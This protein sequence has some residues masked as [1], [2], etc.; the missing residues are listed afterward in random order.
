MMRL[1]FK[2]FSC[3]LHFDHKCFANIN[4][5]AINRFY[6]FL[7]FV[8]SKTENDRFI[9]HRPMEFF[10]N[11]TSMRFG[12]RKIRKLSEQCRTVCIKMVRSHIRFW[13][14]SRK[15]H[16][17]IWFSM[18]AFLLWTKMPYVFHQQTIYT[19]SKKW[20]ITSKCRNAMNF[21]GKKES[22]SNCE[23]VMVV[24]QPKNPHMCTKRAWKS[25]PQ[26]KWLVNGRNFLGNGAQIGVL[27]D[28]CR[29][30]RHFS[31]HPTT[32][33]WAIPFRYVKKTVFAIF[34]EGIA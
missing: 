29:Q 15:Y 22:E 14:S 1:I 2:D 16:S 8:H 34:L 12:A 31:F 26:L 17:N 20:K 10:A 6:F 9:F 7:M 30:C 18:N 28:A 11:I 25:E 19:R 33:T 24:Y 5:S 21:E 4:F 3:L 23:R 13:I 32:H 27:I